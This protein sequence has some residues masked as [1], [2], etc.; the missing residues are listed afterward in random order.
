MVKLYSFYNLGNTCYLNSVLQCFINIPNFKNLLKK[1]NEVSEYLKEKIH[2]DL[3]DDGNYINH[4]HLPQQITRYFSKKFQI[5]QQ[6][7]VHEFFLELLDTI[8]VKEFYGKQKMNITCSVCGN[9]SSTFEDFSTINLPCE[10]NGGNVTDLFIK[11]LEKEEIPEYYCEKCKCGILAEKKIFLYR[12][13]EFLVVVL[14]SYNQSGMKIH[15]DTIY[16]ET[17]KIKQ[18]Q[19]DEI[20]DYTLYCVIYHHGNS[21]RGHYNCI[22][23][24]ND[25]WFLIDDDTIQLHEKMVFQGGYMLFYKKV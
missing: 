4:K 8:D 19:T 1:E 2:T 6:H 7:D 14:K 16:P 24:V 9:I 17:L 15:N 23:K 18:T 3:T 10:E 22:V 25:K 5:F 12:L 21:Q 11:Y 20:F 13:P